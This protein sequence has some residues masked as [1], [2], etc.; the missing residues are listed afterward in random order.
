VRRLAAHVAQMA[1]VAAA[2]GSTGCAALL[3]GA[4]DK[5]TATSPT[6]GARVYVDGFDATAAPLVVPNDRPHVLIVRAP[7]YRDSVTELDPEVKPVPIVLD[8]VLT[9]PTV[10]IAPL[11][12][13]CLGWWTALDVP[14]TPVTLQQAAL[15]TRARP[16]YKVADRVV[17]SVPG[18][19]PQAA[20][21]PGAPQ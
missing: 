2:T 6:P 17:A 16:T 11:T 21:T 3:N 5:V 7:G 15:A 19:A 4:T 8:V 13:L 18:G 20:P 9:V 14:K 1:L 10:A 12:D